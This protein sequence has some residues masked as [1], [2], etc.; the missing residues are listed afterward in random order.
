MRT[1]P[2]YVE[3]KGIG[4]NVSVGIVVTEAAGHP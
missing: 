3:G 2:V 1:E 4:V